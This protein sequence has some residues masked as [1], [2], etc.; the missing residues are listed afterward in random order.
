MDSYSTTGVVLFSILSGLISYVMAKSIQY[1]RGKD[2]NVN[3]AEFAFIFTCSILLTT[4]FIFWGYPLLS[5]LICGGI[6]SYIIPY[7][8]HLNEQGELKVPLTGDKGTVMNTEKP[9]ETKNIS[10]MPTTDKGSS[11]QV[12][13]QSS[14]SSSK[15]ELDPELAISH[16]KVITELRNMLSWLKTNNSLALDA[17]SGFYD[18]DFNTLLDEKRLKAY[19]KDVSEHL[20]WIVIDKQSKFCLT[21]VD[22]RYVW[23]KRIMNLKGNEVINIWPEVAIAY[24][25]GETRRKNL[26]IEYENKIKNINHSKG[27]FMSIKQFFD[28]NNWYTNALIKEA[29]NMD[30]VL[31][32]R[33]RKDPIYANSEFKKILNKEYPEYKKTFNDQNSYLV[34]KISD[35]YVAQA[36]AKKK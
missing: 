23:V 9:Q 15:S 8:A 29:N 19:D 20:L 7:L 16:T 24:T 3:F 34:N 14:S 22:N 2:N 30:N 10:S 26:G 13:G 36:A 6:G 18:F 27:Y 5:F 28:I 25:E 31:A 35:A 12:K 21:F 17:W 32:D 1:L 11:M 33:I 4:I